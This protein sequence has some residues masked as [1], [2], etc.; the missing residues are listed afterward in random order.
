MHIM[1]AV[2]FLC[3]WRSCCHYQEERSH[4]PHNSTLA[5]VLKSWN[6]FAQW[7]SDIWYIHTHNLCGFIAFTFIRWN[8]IVRKVKP[9]PGTALQRFGIS[10]GASHVECC[11]QCIGSLL[12]CT[13]RTRNAS[14]A[15]CRDGWLGLDIAWVLVGH[16]RAM[17]WR[18]KCGRWIDV[19]CEAW[20]H[21][22]T[23]AHHGSK[24]YEHSHFGTV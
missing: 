13:L 16:G 3:A 1:Y 2:A 7:K 19:D 5:N 8:E 20:D 15:V 18:Y 11:A 12:S 22:L 23:M 17:P 24:W 6:T 4:R 9:H 10:F 21:R 14:V